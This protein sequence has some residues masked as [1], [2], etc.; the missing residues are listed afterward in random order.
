LLDGEKCILLLRGVK[1]FLS[2][3]YK[4]EDHKRYKLLSYSG[5]KKFDAKKAVKEVNEKRAKPKPEDVYRLFEI[6][7]G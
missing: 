6:T 4:A 5:A 7:G 1:P 3:K 2:M